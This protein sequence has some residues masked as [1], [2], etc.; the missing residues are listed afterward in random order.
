MRHPWTTAHD[1]RYCIV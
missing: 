1:L